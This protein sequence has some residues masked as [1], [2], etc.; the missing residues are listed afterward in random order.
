MFYV[1]E[2]PWHGLGGRVEEAPNSEA[3]M[4][5]AGLDWR[6]APQ[7]V[8]LENGKEVLNTVAN[9]RDSDGSVLGVVSNRDY[10]IKSA[11]P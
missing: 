6:V 10:Q 3:A 8:Y 4:R 1:R 11:F 2:T 5:L 9:V 7:K